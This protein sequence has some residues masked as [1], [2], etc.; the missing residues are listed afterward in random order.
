MSKNPRIPSLDGLRAI[1]IACVLLAHLSGTRNFLHSD[2]FEL[3]GNF[4][5]RVFFVISGYLITSLLLHERERTGRIS[6]RGFYIRR[7]YRI[8]PAAYAFMIVAIVVHWKTLP[9]TNILTA[10]TY[11]SSYYHGNWVMGHLWSLSVEEQ[12]YLLWPLALLLFFPVRSWML[13][14]VI[15]S[16]PPLRILFWL[17]WG[18]R[19]LEYPFPVMMDALAMGCS[20]ALLQPQLNRY[21]KLIASRWFL[22]VPLATGFTPLLQ[23]YSNRL[24]QV[25]G[26]TV[27]HAGI[28]LSIEHAVRKRYALLNLR[29]VVWLGTLSYSL[30]LWQQPFL[31]RQGSGPWSAFP[32][33]LALAMLCAAAS[34][35]F[36]EQ[37]FLAMRERW[38][39]PQAGRSSKGPRVNR[40][41][42]EMRRAS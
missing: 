3:Y 29:P 30:Y 2:V 27:M 16:G 22:L 9:W 14:A 8:F 12:F 1:S 34:Y 28:A 39:Q 40:E 32:L 42:I 19:G 5:V 25:V 10:V 17:L 7:V 41:E 18:H 21:A 6:L 37:P 33:N 15:A 11:T 23:L 24:Y 38:R 31:N 36:V 20:L 35:Y 4:G 13:G 26:L